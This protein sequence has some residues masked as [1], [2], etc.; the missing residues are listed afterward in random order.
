MGAK[1]ILGLTAVHTEESELPGWTTWKYPGVH[2]ERWFQDPSKPAEQLRDEFIDYA[3]SHGWEEETR[4][5]TPTAWIAQHAHRKPDDYMELYIGF[6]G[7]EPSKNGK[8][9]VAIDY[10]LAVDP[11]SPA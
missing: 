6:E 5:T 8:V 11:D 3:K 1:T 2:L 9:L 4:I 7:R 10:T